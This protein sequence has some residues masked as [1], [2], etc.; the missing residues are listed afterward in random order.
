MVKQLIAGMG[1]LSDGSGKLYFGLGN[2]EA[3]QSVRVIRSN[4]EEEVIENPEV[5]RIIKV[6]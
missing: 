2:D 1:L 3:V 6:N 5:D 4:G